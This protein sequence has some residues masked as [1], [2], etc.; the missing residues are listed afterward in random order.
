M[1]GPVGFDPRSLRE[2]HPAQDEEPAVRRNYDPL[3]GLH[4]QSRANPYET[5]TQQ[6]ELVP[7]P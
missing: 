6:A 2:A 1:F 5:N 4:N 7:F 3:L